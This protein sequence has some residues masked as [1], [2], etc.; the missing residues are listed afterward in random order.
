MRI[1]IIKPCSCSQPP[2][3]TGSFFRKSDS[4][5]IQRWKCP[6]CKKTFSAATGNLCFAQKKRRLNPLIQ[7]YLLGKVSQR[8]ISI[9]LKINRK[10]VARKVIFLGLKHHLSRINYLEKYR[11]QKTLKLQFDDMITF[12][13]TKCKPVAISLLVEEGSRKILD[14]EVSSIAANGRLAEISRKKYGKREDHRRR[15]WEKL[16]RRTQSIIDE[17]AHFKSDEY[18]LYA[19]VL[20]K[21]FPNSTHEQFKGRKGCVVGQGELKAGGWDPLFSLNHSAAMIRDGLGRLVRKTWCTTKRLD[22]LRDQL[23][24]YID[25]HNRVLTPP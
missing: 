2:V 10:T 9:F 19:D 12:E 7:K 24:I 14:F 4:K 22:R 16:F 15:G 21:Y 1:K 3:K 25:Y 23:E 11:R 18:P 20:R 17:K 6:I 8:R 13:H 5:Y